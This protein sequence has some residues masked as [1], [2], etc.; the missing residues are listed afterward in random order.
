MDSISACE[1]GTYGPGCKRSCGCMNGASCDHI[2]GACT[3]TKGWRGAEC[4]L[5]CPQGFYDDECLGRY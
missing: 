3:C 2:S 4:K 5:P 1:E